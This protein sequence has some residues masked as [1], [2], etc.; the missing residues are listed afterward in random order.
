MALLGLHILYGVHHTIITISIFFVLFSL[1]LS[2]QN[3]EFQRYD[4]IWVAVV[5]VFVLCQSNQLYFYLRSIDKI[6]LQGTYLSFKRGNSE[7]R[8][9]VQQVLIFHV[10]KPPVLQFFFG[11]KVFFYF[12]RFQKPSYSIPSLRPLGARSEADVQELQNFLRDKVPF[13]KATNLF[14]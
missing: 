5:L 13:H 6:V 8:I 4:Q 2:I 12:I 3:I 10:M 11:P 1:G 14:Y 9:P 7:T